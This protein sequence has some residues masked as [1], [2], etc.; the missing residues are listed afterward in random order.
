MPTDQAE[1]RSPRLRTPLN[2]RSNPYGTFHDPFGLISSV[3][4]NLIAG[5]GDVAKGRDL[6]RAFA[7]IT[8]EF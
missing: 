7:G 4:I 3:A 6:L 2:G 8:R 1:F 5:G